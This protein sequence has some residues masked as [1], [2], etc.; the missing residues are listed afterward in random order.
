M[1]RNDQQAIEGLFDRLADAERRSGPRDR[2][3]ETFIRERIAEQ[4]GAPYLMAQTII[5]QQQALEAAQ[6]E[7][8]NLQRQVQEQRQ[9]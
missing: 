3:A 5:V 4:P 2:E 7:L 9:V 1:D 8:E 6:A